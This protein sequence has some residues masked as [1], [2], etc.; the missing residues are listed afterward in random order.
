[1]RTLVAEGCSNSFPADTQSLNMPI[2]I[3]VVAALP[4]LQW[5]RAWSPPFEGGST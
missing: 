3:Q 2:D 1:M 4:P 5:T